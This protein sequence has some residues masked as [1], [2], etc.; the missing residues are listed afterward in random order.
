MRGLQGEALGLEI[1]F[2]GVAPPL[3]MMSRILAFMALRT[4]FLGVIWIV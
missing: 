4:F 3:R 2:T 1:T